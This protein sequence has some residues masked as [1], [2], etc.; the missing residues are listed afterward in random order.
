LGRLKVSSIDIEA[1]LVG[2]SDLKIKG[3]KFSGN[4]SHVYK[5][6]VLHHG[7]LLFNS[8][9][10]I[11]EESIKIKKHQI[12]DKAVNSN[13]SI[14][15]NIS[16][17]L[18]DLVSLDEFKSKLI[19]HIKN[20]FPNIIETELTASQT[21]EIQQLV[22]DKYRKWDWNFG[23]SPRY[24]ISGNISINQVET[25]IKFHFYKG[26]ISQ[27]ETELTDLKPDHLIGL[28]HEKSILQEK[29]NLEYNDN[30]SKQLLQLLF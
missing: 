10:S 6:K 14:V 23:Y 18:E 22:K 17:H 25:S 4:A 21:H 13:R 9:L 30:L 28:Q 19:N 20:E 2:K 24:T 3:K 1:Q 5:N 12:I 29:M 16:D 11:L 26:F 7:T 15:T 8:N 27:I